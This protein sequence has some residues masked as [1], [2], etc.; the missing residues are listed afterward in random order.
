M[1]TDALPTG[2]P[3]Q[4]EAD[5]ILSDGRTAHVRPILPSDAQGITDLHARLSPETIYYRFFTPLPKLS[6][7][8]LARFVHVDYLDRMA[9]VAEVGDQL[10]AVARYD[11]T[12]GQ[13]IAEVAFLVDDAHQGRG[14]GSIMLEQLARYATLH[15]ITAF[16]ADT[17]AENSK[18]LH[19]FKDAGYQLER[20]LADGVVRVRFELTPTQASMEAM[21]RR[22]QRATARSVEALLHPSRVALVGASRTEGSVGDV[23]L[24]NL[25]SANFEG[26]IIPVNPHASAVRGVQTVPALTELPEPVDLVIVAVNREEV[27]GVLA[28]AIT[29]GA[30]ILLVVA[31]G[32]SDASEE[33]AAA[34]RQLVAVARRNGLRVLGPN[35]MGVVNPRIG[36]AATLAPGRV[37]P[38]KVSVHAQSGPLS[39]AILAELQRAGIGIASFVSSGNKADISGNDLLAYLEADEHTELVLLYLEN[40]GNPRTFARVARRVSQA[41]PILAVKSR[42]QH[43][44]PNRDPHTGLDPD[45]AV[46]ALLRATGVLRVDTLEQLVWLAQTIATQPLPRGPRV[47]VLANVGGPS[48]LVVDALRAS[49]LTLATLAQGTRH[50]LAQVADAET[51]LDNPVELPASA[52][53]TKWGDALALLLADDGVDA[54]MV[55]YVPTVV[56]RL[57][58]PRILA[59]STSRMPSGAPNPHVDAAARVAEAIALA[60]GGRA[61]KPVL[62]NFLALPGVPDALSSAPRPIPAFAFPEP[63]PIALG[64]MWQYAKWRSRTPGTPLTLALAPT[65]D[66]LAP[67]LGRGRHVLRGGDAL[68]VLESFSLPRR[69]PAGARREELDQRAVRFRLELTVDDRFGP[70]VRGGI[71]GVASDLMGALF[72]AALPQTEEEVDDFVDA[73]PGI[74]ILDGYSGIPPLDRAMLLTTTRSLVELAD[75]RW[76]LERVVLDPLVVTAKGH[77]VRDAWLAFGEGSPPAYATTRSLRP[78]G[79]RI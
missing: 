8:M 21:A 1:D 36:L 51:P 6:E 2:Y 13:P 55:S 61:D 34:E 48:P 39:L 71:A 14:L 77:Y 45:E 3:R 67:H 70:F 47:A 49:G 18:M 38:G 58:D 23:I 52:A 35:S 62:A 29:N 42:R 75:P 43:E 72:T 25:L 64:R 30:K 54:V 73:I 37:L 56:G 33:G 57:D 65:P 60:A 50:Q 22:E 5:T 4:W 68:L 17:L 59:P 9:F 78:P 74:R 63:G 32:Y 69:P 44:D 31:A 24:A 53:A 12:P 46:E 76:H 10:V 66:A 20:E 41:K 19:V 27:P 26:T 79:T 16:V 40:F 11:R 7:A 28:D 15:G